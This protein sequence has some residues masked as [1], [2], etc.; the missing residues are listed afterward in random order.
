MLALLMALTITLTFSAA[1]R[2][3]AAARDYCK[4]GDETTLL[5]IDRTTTYTPVDQDIL[6]AGLSRIFRELGPGDRLIARTI[7]GDWTR[8]DVIYDA[9]NAGCPNTGVLGWLMSECSSVRAKRDFIRQ[10]SDLT[11]TLKELLQTPTSTTHS[12]IAQTLVN[13]S[14]QVTARARRGAGHPLGTVAIF[15][16]M[17]EN[18]RHIPASRIRSL[19]PEDAFRQFERFD[20]IPPLASVDVVVFGFGRSQSDNRQALDPATKARLENTWRR[21]FESG[22]ARSVQFGLRY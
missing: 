16:D 19:A 17:V 20:L 10:K 3:A 13:A 5:L 6:V 4:Y 14:K 21:L 15:S 22:A 2:E 18:S 11:R 12:D 9:C 1:L 8:S 7:L